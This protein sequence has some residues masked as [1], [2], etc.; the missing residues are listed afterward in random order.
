MTENNNAATFYTPE[1]DELHQR[2]VNILSNRINQDDL[3]KEQEN[4]KK[5][6]VKHLRLQRK[7]EK[8]KQ[9]SK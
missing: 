2:L 1:E 7:L 8:R 5:E 3:L 4:I 6:E 9:I